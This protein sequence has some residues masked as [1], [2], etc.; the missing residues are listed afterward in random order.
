MTV[1]AEVIL[2]QQDVLAIRILAQEKEVLLLR[3]LTKT[4]QDVLEEEINSFKYYRYKKS[5]SEKNRFFVFN[6]FFG[7]EY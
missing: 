5:D 1:E 4:D 6:S 3:F 7:L 2:D